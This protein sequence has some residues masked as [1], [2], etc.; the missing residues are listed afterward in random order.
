[1][2]CYCCIEFCGWFWLVDFMYSKPMSHQ[3]WLS[4][5]PLQANSCFWWF[6]WK[7]TAEYLNTSCSWHEGYWIK[8]LII[9]Q[10]AHSLNS[11]KSLNSLSAFFFLS[12]SASQFSILAELPGQAWVEQPQVLLTPQ[13]KRILLPGRE[14]PLWRRLESTYRPP[15]KKQPFPVVIQQQPQLNEFE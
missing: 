14:S 3:I 1:M 10:K 15:C 12:F 13:P 6:G 4:Q 7:V 11:E 2:Y 8:L 5:S 9:Y